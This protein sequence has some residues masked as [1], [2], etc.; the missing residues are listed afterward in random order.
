MHKTKFP[1]FLRCGAEYEVATKR[2]HSVDV[3]AN[4][5]DP[6]QIFNVTTEVDDDDKTIV[7]SN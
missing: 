3:Y 4:T 6:T 7:T 1:G 5:S 2:N